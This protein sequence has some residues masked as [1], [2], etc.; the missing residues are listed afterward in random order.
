MQRERR[1]P[2]RHCTGETTLPGQPGSRGLLDAGLDG[3]SGIGIGVIWAIGWRRIAAAQEEGTGEA[4]GEEKMAH[5]LV[6]P[7]ENDGSNTLNRRD[8]CQSTPR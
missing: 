1:F 7:S 4:C 6:Y 3:W 2:L 8:W 5:E